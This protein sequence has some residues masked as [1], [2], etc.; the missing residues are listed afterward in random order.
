MG[1][2][3]VNIIKRNALR[4]VRLEKAMRLLAE[5]CCCLFHISPEKTLDLHLVVTAA[6]FPRALFRLNAITFTY[7]QLLIGPKHAHEIALSVDRRD[8]GGAPFQF[9]CTISPSAI[10]RR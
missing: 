4:Q 2:H 8:S 7:T 1:H 6:C 5:T 9:L 3:L 10:G